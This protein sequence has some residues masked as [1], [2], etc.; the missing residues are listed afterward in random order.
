MASSLLI[1]ILPGATIALGATAFCFYTWCLSIGKKLEKGKVEASIDLEDPVSHQLISHVDLVRATDNF[2]EDHMLGFGGFGKV[3]KGQ[4][5]S[6][7]VVAIKVLDMR[8]K[9]SVKSFDTECRVFRMA[10]HRN[11]IRVI[12]TCSNMDF[13]ALVLQYMP[14]G[15]L[16]M[17]LHHSEDGGRQFGFRERL[18]AMLDVSMAMEYLHHGYHEVVLHC[19]LKPSNV[20]F[21]EDM[22]AHVA[23]FGIARLL[24]EYGS[25]GKASRLS[26]VFSYGIM[27]LEVFTGRKP[28]DAM[29]VGELSLRRWVYQSF[30]SELTHVVDARLLQDSSSSCNL[31]GNFLLP[32][33]EVGLL[34]SNDSPCNRIKMSDVVVM[35]KSIQMKYTAWAVETSQRATP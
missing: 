14:N 25:Y 29:F 11:L 6:G 35:L 15:S 34:C 21:D 31:H 9:H 1:I 12:N 33:L 24:Q 27:L 23:D 3:F 20:L 17:L 10:R 19:D 5:S 7:L 2:S 26:D 28:T 22:T 13:I 32:V 8:S 18:G 16:D 30:P 4:L